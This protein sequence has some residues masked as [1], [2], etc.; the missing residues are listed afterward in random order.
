MVVE[1]KVSGPRWAISKV[2]G[3]LR[4]QDGTA[5]VEAVL[6][7]PVFVV[8]IALIAD[9]SLLFNRQA[10]MLRLV[11]D[12][13]R[14]YSTRQLET[15]DD[16]VTWLSEEINV[17]SEDVQIVSFVDTSTVPSGVIVTTVSVPAS[18]LNAI[19]LIAAFRNFRMTVM[20]QH[21]IEV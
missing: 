6:W 16:V 18:D 4:R 17:D 21:Y 11:Q 9:G 19:G 3:F 10:E 20:A 2:T 7:M 12:A 15:T 13:N 5:T 14:A 1:Q 8:L